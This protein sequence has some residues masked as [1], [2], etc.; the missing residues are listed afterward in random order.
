M[1]AGDNLQTA[2]TVARE[3]DMIDARQ[4]V[5]QVEAVVVP[6]SIQHGAKHL[7]VVYKD[8]LSSPEFI[9]GTVSWCHRRRPQT[10]IV[11]LFVL[12]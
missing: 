7:Q 6:A 5:I 4:R 3:C 9:N 2:V 10:A 11:S 12:C 1:C 8:P